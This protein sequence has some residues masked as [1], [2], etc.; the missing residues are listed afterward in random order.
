MS[1]NYL[2]ILMSKS[3]ILSLSVLEALSVGTKSLVNNNIKYPNKISK[4]IYFTE[5]KKDLIS[6]IR[7]VLQ[8]ILNKIIQQEKE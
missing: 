4:L 8:I 2:N 1:E 7:K 5:P 3:E 6:K